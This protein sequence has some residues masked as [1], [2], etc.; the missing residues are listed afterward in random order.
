ME[1]FSEEFLPKPKLT[2]VTWYEI[3]TGDAAPVSNKPYRYD[4]VAQS[5]ID[6]HSKNM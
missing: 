5:I 1:K 6:Y 4:Q 3:D 2:Y